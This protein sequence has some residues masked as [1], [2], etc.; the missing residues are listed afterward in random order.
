M[1]HKL[2]TSN[3]ILKAGDV[4]KRIFPN[5]LILELMEGGWKINNSSV[6]LLSIAQKALFT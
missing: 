5:K 4:S 6:F 1:S 3:N 2:I